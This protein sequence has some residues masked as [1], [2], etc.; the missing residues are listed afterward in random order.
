[1]VFTRSTPDTAAK[2]EV[3]KTGSVTWGEAATVV[4]PW[5]EYALEE[6]IVR[7]KDAGG[8]TSVIALGPE[9]HNEAL[10]QALAMGIDA[11]IT[12]LHYPQR[13]NCIPKRN[14]NLEKG[15]RTPPVASLQNRFGCRDRT[16]PVRVFISRF[17]NRISIKTEWDQSS[18]ASH[19]RTSARVR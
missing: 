19:A 15:R 2:V 16:C 10:K 7:A 11:A 5:D 1:M 17:L 13:I 8:K 6:A 12:T 4:N 3:D 18:S 9:M 14:K